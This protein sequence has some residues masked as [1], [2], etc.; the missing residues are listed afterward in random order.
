MLIQRTSR[1]IT[2]CVVCLSVLT[3]A[4]AVVSARYRAMQERNYADRRVALTTIPALATGSD[5]LTNAARAYAAT[6]DR[7]HFD[8]FV[9]E[10]D[11]ERSREKAIERL[12]ELGPTTEENALLSHAKSGSDKLVL[13]EN[14]AFDAASHGD[15][16][17]AIH[18]VYGEEFMSTKSSIMQA[19]ADFTRSIDSRLTG[20]AEDLAVGA[21]I[22][23]YIGVVTV[24]A[25]AI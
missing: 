5:R 19:I 14:R 15:T 12:R 23:G 24:L 25:N 1:V 10:R 17:S 6:G 2:I 20:Q 22:A 21:R 18:L 11:V 9:H 16:A 4:C 7:R 3:V 8:D 13:I